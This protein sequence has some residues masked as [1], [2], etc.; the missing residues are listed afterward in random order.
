[1]KILLSSATFIMLLTACSP[2][3][4][5]QS[6]ANRVIAKVNGD[7]ITANQLTLEVQ[8]IKIKIDDTEQLSQ[9]LIAGLI[10]R[11]LLAQ[12]TL[13]LGLDR[14]QDVQEAVATAKAQIYAQAY[15][16]KKIAKLPIPSGQEVQQFINEHPQYFA[17]RK[18]VNTIDIAFENSTQPLDLH[19]LESEVTTLDAMRKVL[20]DKGIPFQTMNNSFSTDVLP[21]EMLDK[22]KR[23]KAGDLLFAHDTNKVIVKSV[24]SIEQSFVPATQAQK[25]ATRMLAEKRRQDFIAQELNRLKALA[26]IEVF[27]SSIATIASG[28][29]API[30]QQAK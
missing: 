13:K 26:R 11:Q 18:I 7:E 14:N 19:W 1:M 28:S 25:I 2:S 9:K 24:S 8:K 10:D 20:N 27:E 17:Q 21:S 3:E 15:I 6:H 4:H 16:A 30:N 12:E 5:L 29:N 23:L 22:V